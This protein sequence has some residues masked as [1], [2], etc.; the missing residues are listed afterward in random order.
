MSCAIKLAIST[1]ILSISTASSFP[2][3]FESAKSDLERPSKLFD[4]P[5]SGFSIDDTL[6]DEIKSYGLV[7]N[8]I[9]TVPW[10][11]HS[12]YDFIVVGS[13][14]GGSSVANRLSENSKW[15][16]L[17]IEAGIP[18]NLIVQ[19]PVTVSTLQ[20]T[21]YNWGYRV[22]PQKKACLG[23]KDRRCT[24]PR[25]KSLGGTS[26]INYM[27]HNRGNK[28]DYD[29]W[30]EDGNEGWSYEDVLPYYRKS[31]RFRVPGNYNSSYHGKNGHLCVEHVPYHSPLATEF[32]KAGKDLGYEV[33][34]YNGAE[35]IGFSY[36]QVNMDRGTRCSASKAYLRVERPN[37]DIVTQ[38]QVTKI[39]I[40]EKKRAYG[41]EY[42]KKGRTDKVY[43]RKEVILSAGTIDS[44][45]LL[46]LSGVGPS[47][48]LEELGIEVI[49]DAKVGYNLYEHLGFLGIT[50]KINASVTL[51]LSRVVTNPKNFIDYG[52]H[53][54][55]PITLPGG[56]ESIAFMRTKYALDER[57]DLELL[58][59]GSSIAADNGLSVYKGYGVSDEA[60]KK[61]Y[62]PLENRDAWTVWPI[63]QNPRS[64][65]RIKLKSKD[66]FEAPIIE[67]NFFTHPID[68]EILLE[69]VKQVI[70]I[71]KT[72]RFQAYGSQIHK[73][74]V[75]GCTK[76]AFGSDDYWRCAIRHL[77]AT[78]N[79]VIGT[80]KMGP[81]S[82]PDAVV[83]PQLKVHGIER[84][85]VVDASI[86]PKIPVGHI[87]AGIYMIGEKAADMI[88]ET[89][90]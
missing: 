9:R 20:Q 10:P 58:F 88:K 46:M 48:H 11:V 37:L 19:I 74:K 40:D 27:I 87:N 69:G 24:W 1:L 72:E 89:W 53:R 3:L 39:L 42:K 35:Q 65:G 62:K 86:M 30:A 60:Y 44:A 50:F 90:S 64:H 68:V 15:R 38:A 73:A 49:K 66:P 5:K 4:S 17:L 67:G 57:P 34:D 78:M 26:S 23:M 32:L 61:V 82:D 21:P 2:T 29:E 76:Y 45:K 25:G 63:V 36:L 12:K 54:K 70:N 8:D 79:H 83:D 80:A 77:P 71:S 7:G 16:I 56:P 55:G 51:V 59:I 6:L 81:A 18:E 33:V 75:P 43:V 84:L 47:D 85:R 52:L 28:L 31:E 13:G 14:S 22:Q 41:I